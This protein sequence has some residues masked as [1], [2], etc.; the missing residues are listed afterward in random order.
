MI[1]LI[2]CAINFAVIGKYKIVSGR[3]LNEMNI[4]NQIMVMSL[5]N[6]REFIKGYLNL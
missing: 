2:N 5:I 3:S 4:V 6:T 1:D